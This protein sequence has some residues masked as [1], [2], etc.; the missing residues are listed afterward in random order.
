MQIDRIENAEKAFFHFA[1]LNF[2]Y[3]INLKFKNKK[4]KKECDI[5]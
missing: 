5:F 4:Y 3:S 2:S 1:H